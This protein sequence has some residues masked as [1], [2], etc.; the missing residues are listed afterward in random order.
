MIFLNPSI[1]ILGYCL[2]IV[3]YHLFP[4][5]NFTVT[6]KVKIKISTQKAVETCSVLRC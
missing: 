5:N 6:G 1:H 4:L 3:R 2:E